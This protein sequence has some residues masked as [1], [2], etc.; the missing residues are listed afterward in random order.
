MR[1]TVRWLLENGYNKQA[2]TFS[3]SCHSILNIEYEFSIEAIAISTTL[4]QFM[5]DSML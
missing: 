4:Y 5:D 2:L 3:I 1:N